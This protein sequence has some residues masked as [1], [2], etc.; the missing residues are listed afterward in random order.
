MRKHFWRCKIV[1]FE[2]LMN[3]GGTRN[4]HRKFCALRLEVRTALFHS[5]NASSILAGR[6]IAIFKD[7]TNHDMLQ[8]END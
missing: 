2:K 1:K 4:T 5:A 8:F 3:R 6:K 7:V